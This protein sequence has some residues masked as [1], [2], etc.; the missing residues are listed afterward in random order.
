MTAVWVPWPEDNR[1]ET[2]HLSNVGGY[3]VRWELPTPSTRVRCTV[4]YK[5]LVP[6][7]DGTPGKHKC[8]PAL[9]DKQKYKTLVKRRVFRLFG[10]PAQ[11]AAVAMDKAGFRRMPVQMDI[12]T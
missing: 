12:P 8:N 7:D 5:A 3:A 6:R 11:A 1:I 10:T 4:C 9:A 2:I